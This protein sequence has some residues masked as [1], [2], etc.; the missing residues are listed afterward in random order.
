MRRPRV[1]ITGAASAIGTELAAALAP[2]MEVL[3]GI[4]RVGD[5]VRNNGRLYS[6]PRV[7]AIA[8]DITAPRL[9]L[10]N[11]AYRNLQN[12]LDLIVHAAAI[13]DFGQP[14]ALYE[15]VNRD[16]TQHVLKLTGGVIPLLHVSTAYVCGERADVVLE[17]ELDTGQR[18]ANAYERTKFEAE[19]LVQNANRS[20][21]P[22]AI[23][24]PSIVVGTAR[25][26]VT[27]TFKNVYVLLRLLT[28][29]RVRSI[30]ISHEATLDLVPIDY[31]VAA[32]TE[33]ARRPANLNGAVLHLTGG[34]PLTLR[35][36]SEVLAEYP[37][38]QMPRFMPAPVFDLASLS[39]IERK[40]YERI[41]RP[42]EPYFQRRMQFSTT[43]TE[44][45]LVSRP[46]SRG[47]PF[48]RHLLDYC[49]QV[50]YLG[51]SRLHAEAVLGAYQ[52]RAS[53]HRQQIGAATG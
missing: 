10:G 23:V 16:G 49:L 4:H 9:G 31:V 39:A 15:K 29:G 53:S 13:T 32:T 26:G 17:S 38:L 8:I 1:L 3:A 52:Q 37:P 43:A 41:V 51:S 21:S 12:S 42:Y 35:D 28:E 14:E 50:G 22:T 18:F 48:L 7:K 27:R 11:K 25:R 40:Y 6:S 24:R 19:R 2:E 36:V 33:V 45:L 44:Q 46:F 34:C 47:K 5:L 30:P 20:G